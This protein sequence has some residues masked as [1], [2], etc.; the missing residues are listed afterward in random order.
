MLSSTKFLSRTK[1]ICK[2]Y[3]PIHEGFHSDFPISG[4]CILHWSITIAVEAW[5][6]RV[7]PKLFAPQWPSEVSIL[8]GTMG[9]SCR[10][11]PPA[12]IL[13]IS[14]QELRFWVIWLSHYSAFRIRLRLLWNGV[15]RPSIYKS[16]TAY[17]IKFFRKF[18]AYMINFID[19][20]QY[21]HFFQRHLT[22]A[23]SLTFQMWNPL[24]SP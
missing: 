22:E 6:S 3:H 2:F 12:C 17:M 21:I 18:D 4:S 11:S 24:A 1:R 8:S 16:Y 10:C 7:F 20:A 15:V 14:P 13:L 23:P 19:I 9:S 5:D